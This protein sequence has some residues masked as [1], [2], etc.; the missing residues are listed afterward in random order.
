MELEE[1]IFDLELKLS[2]LRSKEKETKK[3]KWSDLVGNYYQ[4]DTSTFIKV[5]KIEY[6]GWDMDMDC[7]EITMSGSIIRLIGNNEVRLDLHGA[8]CFYEDEPMVKISEEDFLQR[9]DLTV[10]TLRE[11]LIQ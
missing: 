11:K 10:S 1:E 5:R 9:I 2:Q 7:Y 3:E 6:I 4:V 8:A